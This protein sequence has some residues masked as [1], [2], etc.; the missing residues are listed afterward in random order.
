MDVKSPST[1]SGSRRNRMGSTFAIHPCE[2]YPP[3]AE[4]IGIT[5]LSFRLRLSCGLSALCEGGLDQRAG[6]R[7]LRGVEDL[8]TF[9][10]AVDLSRAS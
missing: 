3:E 2:Y 8:E 4:I 7:P 5:S 1:K 10:K 9:F 6:W